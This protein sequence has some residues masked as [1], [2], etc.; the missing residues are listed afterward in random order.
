[1]TIAK[2]AKYTPR[3]YASNNGFALMS[4]QFLQPNE[5]TLRCKYLTH[6]LHE[7]GNVL[8]LIALIADFNAAKMPTKYYYGFINAMTSDGLRLMMWGGE[9]LIFDINRRFIYTT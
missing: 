1:M 2:R 5:H 4:S 9:T 8:N 6:W 3:R 7:F